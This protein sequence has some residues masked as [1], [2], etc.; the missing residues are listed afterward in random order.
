MHRALLFEKRARCWD[1]FFA[2]SF[3]CWNSSSCPSN[4]LETMWNFQWKAFDISKLKSTIAFLYK[5]R[6]FLT[7]HGTLYEICNMWCDGDI[8][9]VYISKTHM[10]YW[11][12]CILYFKISN[13]VKVVCEIEI[14][15][16]EH[17]IY[18]EMKEYL[19]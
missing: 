12:E 15:K 18:L 16:I 1:K 19:I 13:I 3:N 8:I 10:S 2:I 9:I 6:F 11:N 14:W 4:N 17:C 7:Y 5:S